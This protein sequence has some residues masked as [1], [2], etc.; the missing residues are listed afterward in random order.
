MYKISVDEENEGFSVK[1]K[2]NYQNNFM[3][4]VITRIY[5]YEENS[6]FDLW[7]KREPLTR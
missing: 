3:F 4:T 2:E 1:N 6:I 7:G 5:P